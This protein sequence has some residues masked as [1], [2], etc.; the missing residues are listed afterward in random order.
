MEG[1]AVVQR[2]SSQKPFWIVVA[3]VGIAAIIAAYFLYRP[4]LEPPPPP[5]P[6]PVLVPKPQ[7]PIESAPD[8]NPI[9]RANPFENAYQNPFE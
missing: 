6:A 5:A 1:Q 4:R 2:V 7:N 3:A 8:A 9:K